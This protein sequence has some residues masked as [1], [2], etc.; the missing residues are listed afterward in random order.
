MER[1]FAEVAR[2]LADGTMSRRQALSWIG[3]SFAAA[4][5]GRFPALAAAAP[6]P[7]EASPVAPT[8]HGA[9]QRGLLLPTKNRSLEG[10]FGLMFKNLPA[11]EPP[12]ELLIELASGMK[13]GITRDVADTSAVPAGFV[14]LGQFID[15]DLTFDATSVPQQR[16]D[17]LAR[18]N[19]RSPR[20]ELDSVYGDG[21]TKSPKFYDPDDPAKLLVAGGDLPR[22]PDETAIIGDP[23]DDENLITSQMHLAFRKFHNALVDHVRDPVRAQGSARSMRYSRRPSACAGGT[24]SGWWSTTSCRA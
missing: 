23:R 14:F 10:R 13:E 2:A 9:M 24:T 3:A 6:A 7:G 19:F 17:P 1:S 12:D 18:T 5:L 4:V 21:P 11:F 15:H 16:E 20:F 8:Q 22:R